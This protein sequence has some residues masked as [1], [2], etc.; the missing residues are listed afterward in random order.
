MQP[1]NILKDIFGHDAFRGQ[2]QKIITRILAGGHALVIMPTGGG[3]SLC[4]QIPGLALASAEQGI[5]VVISPLIAL[6]KDQVDVLQ[7]RNVRAA[8]INSSLSREQRESSYAALERGACDLLYVT[9]ERFRKPD[10]LAAL[11]KQRVALLAV[12]EAHCIS[13]WGHDFRPD[14]TRLAEIRNLI[15]QPVTI[16]LTATATPEVQEDIIAQLGLTA[17]EVMLFHEGIDRPNLELEVCEVLGQEEKLQ[18]ILHARS[19]LRGPGIVYFSL[20]RSL[21]EMSDLLQSQQIE[22]LVYHGKL[23]SRERKAL[24][25]QFMQG[26][27]RL[28]LATNAFGMGIDKQNIRFV[29]HAEIPGSMESYYQEIGRAGRDGEPS[30]CLL[31]YDESDLATQM[32]FIQWS[33][34][35][36]DFCVRVHDYLHRDAEKINA[37][38]QEWLRDQLHFKNRHDFRLETVL[39]LFDRYEVIDGSLHPLRIKAI[40]PLPQALIN[41]K[42]RQDKL[43]RDQKKLHALLKYVKCKVDRKAYIHAYFGLPYQGVV[44]EI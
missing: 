23:P 36:A 25:E 29:L 30:L 16:A 41:P 31:L 24:Q 28:V 42:E 21:E 5:T 35:D 39:Q 6:M 8:F 40:H 9:P 19:H 14:Y 38:G 1:T 18:N 34:P 44:T 2:Q 26:E 33:N 32:E 20:I 4:Y 15:G 17:A 10:F 7:R 37:F 22:H 43:L 27:D 13:Q 3:K 12:D 11:S